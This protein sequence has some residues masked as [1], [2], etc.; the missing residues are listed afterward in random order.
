[1]NYLVHR[2]V[3]PASGGVLSKGKN[4]VLKQDVLRAI[5]ES[6]KVSEVQAKVYF[7]L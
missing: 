3:V 6:F 7:T 5:W 4:I 2:S 1:M